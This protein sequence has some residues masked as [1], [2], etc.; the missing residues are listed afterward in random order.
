MRIPV[1]ARR[2]NPSVDRPILRKN[3][4]YCQT[5][6]EEGL[7]DWVNL[8]DPSRGIIAR[9][10]LPSGKVLLPELV[11]ETLELPSLELPGLKFVPPA[12]DTRPRVA[13]LRA[14]WD[15]SQEPVPA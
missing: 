5:Q 4:I 10:Y 15:W 9:E 7:A 13:I 8:G 14:G 3:L 6:V 11:D 1:F 2:S 12:T